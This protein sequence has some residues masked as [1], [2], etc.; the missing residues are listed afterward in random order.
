MTPQGTNKKKTF[1]T[2]DFYI[3]YF[4]NYLSVE[5][6][7]EHNGITEKEANLL[8]RE[9]KK[10]NHGLNGFKNIQLVTFKH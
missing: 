8:I 4:N 7:A 9:G 6:I 5:K 3:D 2:L 1:K 10:I